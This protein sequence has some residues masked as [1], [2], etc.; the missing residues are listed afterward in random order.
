MQRSAGTILQLLSVAITNSGFVRFVPFVWL[1]FSWLAAIGA[2][3]T[4]AQ[5]RTVHGATPS[6]SDQPPVRT[7]DDKLALDAGR[8]AP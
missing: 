5:P 3:E 8:H 6:P 4:S 1:G 2:P 7:D